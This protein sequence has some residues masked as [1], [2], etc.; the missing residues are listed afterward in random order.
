MGG[1]G[2]R[3]KGVISLGK[4]VLF[5]RVNVTFLNLQICTFVVTVNFVGEKKHALNNM[6]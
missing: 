1:S 3:V 6:L 2:Q 5:I 4:E